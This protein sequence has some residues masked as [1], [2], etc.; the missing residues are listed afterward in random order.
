MSV[1][2]IINPVAGRGRAIKVW[3]K[4]KE[5]L[6]FCYDYKFTN[7]IG[8]A[9]QIAKKAYNDGYKIIISV[10]G[11]GTLREVVKALAGKDALLGIIPAGTG[12]D[13]ARTLG[14]PL[15]IEKSLNILKLGSSEEMD[16]IRCNGE[17][18]IN[19]AG[20][21]L[22]AHVADCVNNEI[23]LF[24][25][26]FAYIAALIKTLHRF[27]PQDVEINIDGKILKR[28]AWLV[29]ISNGKYYGGGMMICPTAQPDDG[30]LDVSIVNDVRKTEI[31]RFLPRVFGGKHITHRAYETF[32]GKKVI[33]KSLTPI[34]VHTDGDIIG[35]TPKEFEIWPKA[36]NIIR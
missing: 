34:L 22:D 27:N 20:A 23:R 12:N 8:E 1:F 6:N 16:L 32:R 25:G 5:S 17:I 29:T 2:F 15:D 35:V 28:K 26:T 31:L 10:G 33:V 19:A 30:Y 14:I 3:K 18:F 9:T 7:S 4:I 21:G 11:D 24:K 36:I 13:F